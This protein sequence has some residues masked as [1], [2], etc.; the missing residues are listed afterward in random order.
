MIAASALIRPCDRGPIAALQ[1]VIFFC[2][3]AFM[4]WL[5]AS[6]FAAIPTVDQYRFSDTRASILSASASQVCPDNLGFANS[7]RASN[8][9]AATTST[10]D[11][12]AASGTLYGDCRYYYPE[13]GPNWYNYPITRVSACP[14]NSSTSGSSCI[15]NSGFT[16]NSAHT[17]CEAPPA[18]LC[19][20]LAGTSSTFNVTSGYTR[21]SQGVLNPPILPDGSPA[22]AGYTGVPAASM[23][24]N[25]CTRTRGA[26]VAS[27]TSSEPTATGLYRMSDDWTFT[28]TATQCTAS[29]SDKAAL[30][31]TA[32][33]PPC[34]GFL[35]S[36]NGKSTCVSTSSGNTAEQ[37]VFKPS[38]MGNPAAGSAGGASSIPPAGG[39]GGN[40]GGPSSGSDG[41][42]KNS[43]GS[44]VNKSSS[45]PTGSV[46][47]SAAGQQQAA[48]GAPGQPKCSMDETG[49][50]TGK[51]DYGQSPISD[52][53]KSL[54]DA[55]TAAT[56]DA[57][58]D[59]SWGLVPRWL[60]PVGGCTPSILYRLPPKL[61]LMPISIDLCPHLPLIYSLMN[62][63]WVVWTFI[64]IT[65]MV[66]RV[67]TAK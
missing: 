60:Q 16:E 37:P 4:A 44:V 43:D 51:T 5:P 10:Y 14:A 58:K 20:S 52:G 8:Q 42:L 18:N 33:I 40:G 46:A 56:G 15:C 36:I 32:A 26:P 17:A 35:G 9:T 12:P 47:V 48:C 31:P 28:A 67:T 6:S 27:W 59:T 55:M 34:A 23:C 62:L 1:R 41:S 11:T 24:V 38:L 65:E 39:T 19:D 66:F 13:W 30:S 50:P 45:P 63:L 61:G 54:G 64:A 21:S 3:V 2:V 53:F 25:G 29:T 49:T 22:P 7:V 57:G